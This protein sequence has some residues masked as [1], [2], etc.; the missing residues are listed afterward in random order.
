MIVSVGINTPLTNCLSSLSFCGSRGS[1]RSMVLA[2]NE[3]AFDCPNCGNGIAVQY[4]HVVLMF[5]VRELINSTD[6]HQTFCECSL[7]DP[8]TEEGRVATV[9]KC[10]VESVSGPISH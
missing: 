10:A 9:A 3:F 7:P 5:A 6:P 2:E 4:Y 8:D 1:C